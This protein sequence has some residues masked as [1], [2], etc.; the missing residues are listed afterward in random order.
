MYQLLQLSPQ[1]LKKEIK[2]AKQFQE[3]KK[4]IFAMVLRSILLILFAIA[5]IVLFSKIFGSENN[6]IAVGSFCM[7]LGIRFVS[8]GY[9]I[10]E[11]LFS[12][13]TVL[14]LM[15]LGGIVTSIRNSFLVFLLHFLFVWIILL[16]IANEPIM[17]N[18]GIYVFSYL[19][20]VENP[21]KNELLLTRFLS[22]ICVFIICGTILFLKHHTK[23]KDDHLIHIFRSFNLN[24]EKNIWQLRLAL[25][26]SSALFIGHL[27]DSPRI[28]WIGYACMSVLLPFGHYGKQLS[29]RAFSRISAVIIGSILFGVIISYL[30][31]KY[32]FIVGPIAGL[33]I[34]FS[35]T[36]FWNNVLNCFGALLLASELF[37][38][39]PSI[40]FRIQNNIIGAILALVFVFIFEIQRK[41]T[42]PNE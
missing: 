2:A 29:T 4:F 25:G 35:D 37:G 38:L 7:F 23:N 24:N 14:S 22:L 10:K 19:F 6:S 12:L 27:L 20:I 32:L 15:F 31:E 5:Y 21:V 28:V 40:Q 13:G 9:E 30:P 33:C 26:I 39:S 3:K 34:G 41:S 17:G 42:V 18:A 16:L 8:Y 11:S 1:A 36:N